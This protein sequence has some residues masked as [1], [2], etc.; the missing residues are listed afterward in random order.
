MCVAGVGGITW[1]TLGGGSHF[2]KK[3]DSMNQHCACIEREE[4]SITAKNTE[5]TENNIVL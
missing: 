2:P 1:F 5:D 4:V 3:C